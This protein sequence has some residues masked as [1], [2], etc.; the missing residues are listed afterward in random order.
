MI[1]GGLAGLAATAALISRGRKVTLLEARPRWG[2]RAS[3]FTDHQTGEEIDNCQHVSMGCC[4]NLAHLCRLTGIETAFR[5]QPQLW[6]V[7][8]AGTVTSFRALPI[9]APLHLTA[10]L[11]RLPYLTWREK[12]SLALGMGALAHRREASNTRESFADW[13]QRH[14]QPAAVIERFW[15][16]VLVSALSES[17]DRMHVAAARK[18]FVDGFLAHREAWEVWLPT[19]PLG[20][21]YGQQLQDWFTA[22]GA[23]LQLQAGV[24]SLEIAE[25]KVTAVCLRDG[26][27]LQADQYVLAVSHDRVALLL[28][29]PYRSHPQVAALSKLE[30]APISSIH[31]WFDREVI[32]LPHAALVGRISQWLFN[33]TRIQ[34][35][36]AEQDASARAASGRRD[37]RQSDSVQTRSA[38]V[39]NPSARNSSVESWYYQVVISN[40]RTVLERPSA[41]L[42]AAV[43]QELTAIWPQVAEGQ[44]LRSRVVTEHK[45]ALSQLPGVDEFR[46]A[47]QSP[48]R[49]LQ[50]AGDW[51][52]TG[53]PSTMEGAVRSGYQAAENILRADADAL[54][55]VQPDLP[56]SLLARWC[57]HL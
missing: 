42:I 48:L 20:Q 1:G 49:N 53:W 39:E 43:V 56:V 52:R 6:F 5:R 14:R 38:A 28:P 23:V 12:F 33:R 13:L 37:S 17:L 57:L 50:W 30:S 27:R 29:E 25:G 41:E 35:P 45:A 46:P 15:E 4:T 19:V 36:D 47:Q 51:T 22:N 32:P 24:Q 40:S 7:G 55:C 2:G 54:P 3:S 34:Q 16:V 8:P 18:V 11:G 21:L 44:L 31:L 9:P 10:A 26:S